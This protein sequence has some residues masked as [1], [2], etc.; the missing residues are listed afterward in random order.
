MF[1]HENRPHTAYLNRSWRDETAPPGAPFRPLYDAEIHYSAQPVA[2]VVA[3]DLETAIYASS[4]VQAEYE[5][6]PHA[7]DLESKRDEAYVPPKKRSGIAPPPSPRGNSGKAFAAPPRK[8]ERE[9]ATP[10]EHHNPMEPHATTAVWEGD[11]KLTVYD[12]TQG[13]QNVQAYLAQR[14]RAAARTTCAS[15]RPSSAARSARACGR[16][17][18]SS[19][20]AMAA[21]RARAA[22]PRGADARADVH[23]SATARTRSRRS[24]SAPTRTAR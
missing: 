14:V 2:L 19:L 23:A 20:A 9:Y 22:G 12:K 11:G 6:A 1:T 16:S 13:V 10:F 8:L 7:T 4:L 24:P 18:S 15:S 5:R 3:E 21:R 17:T